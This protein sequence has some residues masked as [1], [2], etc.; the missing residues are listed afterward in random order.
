MKNAHKALKQC[1][2]Q[3]KHSI[4]FVI[5]IIV[6]TLPYKILVSLISESSSK[7]T[8]AQIFDQWF[9]RREAHAN[10]SKMFKETE[11][12]STESVGAMFRP[13]GP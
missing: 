9:G 13:G 8:V 7:N 4:F 1:L 3:S 5:T 12:M 10:S 11:R 6:T 2:A